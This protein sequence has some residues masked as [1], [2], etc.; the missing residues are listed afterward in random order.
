MITAQT[1]KIPDRTNMVI[2]NAS[3]GFVLSIFINAKATER[4][5]RAVLTKESEV[6]SAVKI[7]FFAF[8]LKFILLFCMSLPNF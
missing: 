6:L 2:V 8:R 5:T 3:M 7:T 1:T 4:Q